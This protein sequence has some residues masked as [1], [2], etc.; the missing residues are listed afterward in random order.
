MSFLFILGLIFG[1]FL[2]AVIYRYNTGIT[3]K[4]RSFCPSCGGKLR[5]FELIPILSFVFQKGRCKNCSGKISWQY[6]LVEFFTALLF[7]ATGYK[8]GILSGLDSFSPLYFSYILIIWCLFIIIAIYDLRHKIIPDGPVYALIFISLSWQITSKFFGEVL[9]MQTDGHTVL[10]LVTGPALFLLMASF[11]L[12]SRG[13]WMGFGDAKLVLGI[14]W[15]LGF[16]MGISGVILGFW[17][18]AIV[19]IFLIFLSHA[20]KLFLGSEKFTMKSEIPFGPFLIVG[21]MLA[22]FFNL[23]ILSLS[24]FL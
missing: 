12:V 24:V 6:P 19:G 23:D 8:L 17:L 10:D 11:W 1:S 4:G 9:S 20:R 2:N 18:G 22:F 5:W 3:Y 13:H 7:F 21:S 14:G 15:F 16:E